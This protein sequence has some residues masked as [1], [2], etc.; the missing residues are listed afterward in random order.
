MG[1]AT[2]VSI[3]S[4]WDAGTLSLLTLPVSVI[5]RAPEDLAW[6]GSGG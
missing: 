4:E 1:T 6:Q 2:L 3:F 5:Q